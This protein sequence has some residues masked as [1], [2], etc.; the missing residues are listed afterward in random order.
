MTRV[1]RGITSLKR[2]RKVLRQAKGYHLG[3]STKERMAKEAI[4][5]AGIHAFHDRRKKKSNMR[6]LWQTKIG[7]SAKK[8]NLSYSKLMGNLKKAN[9]KLNR[10]VLALLAEKYPEV[11]SKIISEISK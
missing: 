3:R 10:K 7:S 4:F 8:E 6:G 2:R 11:F 5:H 1:K 9:I